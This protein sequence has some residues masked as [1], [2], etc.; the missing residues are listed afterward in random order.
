MEP[1][2]LLNDRYA[3]MEE[4]LGVGVVVVFERRMFRTKPSMLESV[5]IVLCEQVVRKR[6]NRPLNFAEKVCLFCILVELM[7]AP[8]VFIC[9]QLEIRNAFG[10]PWS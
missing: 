8:C 5:L 6:L 7:P 9:F 1:D 10:R 2:E 4:R 3:A